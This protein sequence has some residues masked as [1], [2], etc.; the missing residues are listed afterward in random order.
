MFSDL[1]LPIVIISSIRTGSTGLLFELEKIFLEKGISPLVLNEPIVYN[2]KSDSVIPFL[3]SIN[4]NQFILKVHA[5]DLQYYP[6]YFIKKLEN[7]SY[8]IIRL[9]RKSIIDQCLSLYISLYTKIWI[10]TTETNKQ[11][12]NTTIEIS[13]QLLHKTVEDVKKFN[14]AIDNCAYKFSLDLIYEDLELTK[15]FT[16]KRKTSITYEELRSRISKMIT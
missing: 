3:K 15:T 7:N 6:K 2:N 14:K 13:E 11:L 10:N 1:K 5:Y 16:I 4:N 9:R 12:E 8:Y